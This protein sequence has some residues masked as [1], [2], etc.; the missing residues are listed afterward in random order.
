MLV[1]RTLNVRI[2]KGVRAGQLIRLAGQGAPGF[3]AA[4]AGAPGSGAGKPGDLL[5]EV[6]FRPHPQFHLDGGD[7]LMTLPAAP[8]EC[9]LGAT[10][11]VTLPDGGKIEVRIPGGA[12]GGTRLRVRGKGLPGEPPGDL[13][14]RIEVHMPPA[15]TARARELYETMARELAFDARVAAGE[16]A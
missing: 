9:A 7:L 2:P 13:L 1:T 12:Q 3:D 16:P 15:N 14:L 8:W 6:Q 5:L 10:V 11:P 4:A